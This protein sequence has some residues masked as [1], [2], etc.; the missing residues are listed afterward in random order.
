M[1]DLTQL[2]LC[3]SSLKNK[4][5]R[6]TTD[7]PLYRS[8]NT[9]KANACSQVPSQVLGVLQWTEGPRPRSPWPAPGGEDMQSALR[10]RW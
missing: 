4:C 6:Y 7:I 9:C 1:K 10:A 3:T 2:I 8:F 5:E